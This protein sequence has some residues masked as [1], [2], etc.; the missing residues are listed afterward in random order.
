MFSGGENLRRTLPTR[1]HPNRRFFNI[2]E[3]NS[4]FSTQFKPSFCIW[5]N[6]GLTFLKWLFVLST[7]LSYKKCT[8]VVW[9]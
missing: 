3:C 5:R 4:I 9:V 1:F 2:F 6:R 8:L 7:W